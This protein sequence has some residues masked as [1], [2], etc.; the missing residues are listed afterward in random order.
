L[1][2]CGATSRID[3]R[4]FRPNIVVDLPG[5]GPVEQ[6][7]PGKAIRMGDSVVLRISEPTERC[8]MTTFAQSDLPADPRVLKCLARDA[9]LRFGV[10]AEVLAAGS[11]ACGDRVSFEIGL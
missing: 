4:R 7:W 9:D 5:E 2:S 1:R 8:A 6:D 10:Y 11:V 3:E